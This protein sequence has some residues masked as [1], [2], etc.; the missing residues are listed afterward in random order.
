[1]EN[2]DVFTGE[3]EI[4]IEKFL[5]SR[6]GYIKKAKMPHKGMGVVEPATRREFTYSESADEPINIG[7]I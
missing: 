1:V 4:S 6:T 2:A 7:R 5:L 3:Y